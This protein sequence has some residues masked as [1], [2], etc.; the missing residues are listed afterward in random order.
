MPWTAKKAAYSRSDLPAG[1]ATIR[2]S[3]AR[4]RL[5]SPVLGEERLQR[6]VQVAQCHPPALGL[7]PI[8][9]VEARW[10][11]R[12][13]M[14]RRGRRRLRDV[15]IQSGNPA[16]AASRHIAAARFS[17]WVARVSSAQHVV[18]LGVRPLVDTVQVNARQS[19]MSD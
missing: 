4:F 8:A 17:F 3:R 19:A 5:G 9:A 16:R 12:T 15:R 13:K 14:N 2:L 18:L 7:N 11:G 1:A 10:L 6:A